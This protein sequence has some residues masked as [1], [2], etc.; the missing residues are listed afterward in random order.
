LKY[1]KTG[2]NKSVMVLKQT[3]NGI[4][5][6]KTSIKLVFNAQ[7]P[8]GKIIKKLNPIIRG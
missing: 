6:V 1:N 2:V 5:R 7:L 8:I 3:R 4:K